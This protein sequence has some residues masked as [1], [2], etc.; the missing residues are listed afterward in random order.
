MIK[1]Q[2]ILGSTKP[3]RAGAAVAQW[4]TATAAREAGLE[5]E[6]IDIV[7]YNL[8]LFDEPQSPMMN[9]YTKDH[10]KQWSA[11]IAEADAYLWVTAEYNHSVPGALKNAIDFLRYEWAHKSVGFVSYGVN[12]GSRAVEHLRGIAGELSLADVRE[13]LLLYLDRDFEAYHDF[14]PTAAHAAQLSKVVGEVA[15]WAEA[16]QTVRHQQT[17]NV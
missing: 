2:V 13:Q 15:T 16:M 12:G 8:P 11:K 10:T 5:V 7:D 17:A 1:L 4:V 14:Q 9:Q 3:N 6:L